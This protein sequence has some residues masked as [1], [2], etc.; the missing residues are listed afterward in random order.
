MCVCVCVCECVC[1]CLSVCVC[2]SVFVS[3]SV[4]VCVTV[5]VCERVSKGVRYQNTEACAF[6][7]FALVFHRVNSNPQPPIP[8][9]TI[10]IRPFAAS[11]VGFAAWAFATG[12]SLNFSSAAFFLACLGIFE[13]R[14]ISSRRCRLWCSSLHHPTNTFTRANT[15][16]HTHTLSLSLL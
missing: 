14:R 7:T 15:H 9:C 12:N 11:F 6:A 3:V 13:V 5:K 8:R 4:S 10:A 16:A 2:V 1:E